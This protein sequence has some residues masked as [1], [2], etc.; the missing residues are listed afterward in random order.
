MDLHSQL[1]DY[2]EYIKPDYS[3]YPECDYDL[4][5]TSRGCIRN[6][7]FCVVPK[8]EGPF[9]TV[10][11]PKYFHDPAHKKVM[12]LDNNILADK[13]WF[14]EVTDWIIENKLKLDINQGLDVRLIDKDIAE[15]L[16]KIKRMN[17]WRIAFDSMG[18]K[19]AVIDGVK[20]LKEAGVNV[21]S[22]LFCYVYVHDDSQFESALER[23]K[24][25]KELGVLAYIQLNQSVQH[26]PKTKVLRRWTQPWIFFKCS[27]EG[28]LES[29][30]DKLY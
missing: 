1:P 13:Q 23:C 14:M 20:L 3:I 8:K 28:Y 21:R 9:R 12:L 25:L 22:Y 24:I 29:R 2:I 7:Y 30:G 11:H 17:K 27:Y 10:Q 26:G 16:A 19:Q 15:R 4:G 5:F 18:V 6:C